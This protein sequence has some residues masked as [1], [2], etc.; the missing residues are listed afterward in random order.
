MVPKQL[1]RKAWGC[2]HLCYYKQNEVNCK[3]KKI[4]SMGKIINPKFTSQRTSKINLRW[5]IDL[6]VKPKT[7][8]ASRRIYSVIG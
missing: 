2:F 4:E 7:Y 1:D 6:K 8:E 5:T 3:N